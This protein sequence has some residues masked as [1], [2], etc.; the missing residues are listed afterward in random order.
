MTP[1]IR[2]G[3]RT[4]CKMKQGGFPKSAALGFEP[5]CAVL[6]EVHDYRA[7]SGII[8]GFIRDRLH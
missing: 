5:D 3:S 8:Q 4:Y 7:I 1:V 2:Y 6:Q